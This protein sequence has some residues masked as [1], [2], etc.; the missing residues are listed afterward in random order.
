MGTRCCAIF[1]RIVVVEG[2]PLLMLLHRVVAREDLTRAEAARATQIILHEGATPAQA[3][4]F[5]TAMRMKGETVEEIA[6]A[7]D[8]M[9]AR[10]MRMHAPAGTIDNCGTGGDGKGSLNIS[11]AVAIVV[12]ACGV[13]VAKHGNR[14]VSS[15]SGSA[16][17]LRHLGVEWNLTPADSEILLAEYNLVFLMAP[18]YHPALRHLGEVRQELGM[19]TLFNLLGPLCNPAGVTRQLLGVYSA[20]LVEPVAQALQ[21]LGCEFAWV[22]HGGDG[23]DEL[24]LEAPSR[25]AEVTQTGIRLFDIHVVESGLVWPL[26]QHHLYPEDPLA[27]PADLLSPDNLQ[28]GTPEQNARALLRVLKGALGMY[29]QSVLLNAAAALVVAGVADDVATGVVLATEAIDSG[30]AAQLLSDMAQRSQ[31]LAQARGAS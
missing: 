29:R 10:M 20:D 8:A 18:I 17:V 16:D 21:S 1:L 27:Q 7:A 22:V 30:R 4:A 15:R 3:A 14:A 25:V 19:R 24:S 31:E 26:E 28:G 9:R 2:L 23:S 6:G 12:A 5:L 11:T 13:P